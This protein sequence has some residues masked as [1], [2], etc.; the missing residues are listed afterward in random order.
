MGEYFSKLDLAG[1]YQVR[2]AEE[3]SQDNPCHPIWCVDLVMPFGLTNAP[4]PSQTLMNCAFHEYLDKFVVVYLDDIVVY[5]TTMEEHRDH[6]QK[7]FQKLKEN[8]LYVKREKCSFA[9]ERMN[10]LG[11]VIE[12][13]RVGMEERKIAAIRDWAMPKSVS[14][15]RS[16][17]GLANYYR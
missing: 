7:V 6:L 1:Y 14:E 17:L 9:Q 13:G 3:M 4:P 8:Q 12:C 10:F 16:F 15:L 11:H 5:S 2:I